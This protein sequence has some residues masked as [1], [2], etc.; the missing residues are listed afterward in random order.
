M[1][2]WLENQFLQF[3]WE[4]KRI[5]FP[6]STSEKEPYKKGYFQIYSDPVE[7]CLSVLPVP[8]PCPASSDVQVPIVG[9]LFKHWDQGEN[10]DYQTG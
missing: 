1:Y 10:Y 5:T 2:S 4:T 3:N 7:N 8:N 9:K 6:I